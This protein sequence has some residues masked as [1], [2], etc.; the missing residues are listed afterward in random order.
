MSIITGLK[1]NDINYRSSIGSNFTKQVSEFKDYNQ[2]VTCMCMNLKFGGKGLNLIE[3]TH[4]FLVEPILN[5]DEELQ[6]IG[7]VHRI[8]QTRETF[9]HR[10][11]T[12]KT[13]ESEIYEKITQGNNKWIQ[14]KI[15]IRDLEELF[16]IHLDDDA[17]DDT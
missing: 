10:F 5:A 11:I 13:I 17:D 1:A 8:G 9:V 4:V 6:A 16:T 3:A 12:R 15:T 14:N 7:R 2:I